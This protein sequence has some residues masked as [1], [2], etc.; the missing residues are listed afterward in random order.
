MILQNELVSTQTDLNPNDSTFEK[1]KKIATLV[2]FGIL[3]LLT[4]WKRKKIL[5]FLTIISF[6]IALFY[7]LPNAKGVVKK[8]SF[9]Y[10]LPTKNSTIFFKIEND[11]KVEILEKKNG[12]IKILGLENGFIGWIKEE[13][14]G[15]N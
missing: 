13:S 4:V 3:F 5:I 14:F 7:N 10:I 12:F 15:T 11:Q 6:V 1:Y 8:D 2:L 9:V